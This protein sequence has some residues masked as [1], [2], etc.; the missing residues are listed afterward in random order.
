M[1]NRPR[2]LRTRRDIERQWQDEYDEDLERN[3]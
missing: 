3:D 1:D 2:R